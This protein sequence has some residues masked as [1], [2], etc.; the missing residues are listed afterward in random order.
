MGANKRLNFL[1]P[2]D[3]K[4][5]AFCNCGLNLSLIAREV[6]RLLV[7]HQLIPYPIWP[8]SISF[9]QGCYERS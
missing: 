8:K 9:E 2:K 5:L 1:R 6:L 7:N 4:I 3:L